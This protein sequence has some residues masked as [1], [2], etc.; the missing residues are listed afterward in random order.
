M[1]E[2]I[3]DLIFIFNDLTIFFQH[4]V[5]IKSVETPKNGHY[6]RKQ[7]Q[8]QYR[9]TKLQRKG[10]RFHKG[11]FLFDH[12]P[13]EHFQRRLPTGGLSNLQSARERFDERKRRNK[14]GRR[15]KKQPDAVPRDV[16]GR[17]CGDTEGRLQELGE[18]LVRKGGVHDGLLGRCV[19]VRLDLPQRR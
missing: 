12:Q 3:L 15:K 1:N 16:Q 14:R 6:H 10:V 2:I 8:I 7:F 4:L 18:R 13:A 5:N 19:R 17:S 11:L 9:K